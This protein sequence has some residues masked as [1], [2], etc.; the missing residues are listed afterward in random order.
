MY[1]VDVFY[2]CFMEL[3]TLEVGT[4]QLPEEKVFNLLGGGRIFC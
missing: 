3:N 4:E 1:R 2:G